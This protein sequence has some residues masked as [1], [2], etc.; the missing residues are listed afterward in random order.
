MYLSQCIQSINISLDKYLL[1]TSFVP[2]ILILGTV[3]DEAHNN[4]PSL[5]TGPPPCPETHR[6]M[7]PR[8]YVHIMYAAVAFWPKGMGNG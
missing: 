2:G 6:D 8:N 1:R 7:P 3:G 4:F 5:E